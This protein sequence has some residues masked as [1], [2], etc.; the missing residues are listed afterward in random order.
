[1]GLAGDVVEEFGVGVGAARERSTVL[2]QVPEES[3]LVRIA[4]AHL[5]IVIYTYT[6]TYYGVYK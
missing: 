3:T 6:C 5:Y 2:H 4:L 1:M